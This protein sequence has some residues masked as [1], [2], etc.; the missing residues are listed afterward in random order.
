MKK[1]KKSLKKLT[2]N[3]K[4]VSNLEENQVSGGTIVSIACPTL[5]CPTR[6]NCPTFGNCPTLRI[7]CK[8]TL[9]SGCVRTLDCS[10]AG[11]PTNFVC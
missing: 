9:D 1:N 4:V 3:K 5:F 2:L 10:L 8:V 7:D 11:C 6:F